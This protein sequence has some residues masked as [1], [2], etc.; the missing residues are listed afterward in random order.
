MKTIKFIGTIA[1]LVLLVL[2]S[3]MTDNTTEAGSAQYAG[4]TVDKETV[5]TLYTVD[6]YETLTLNAPTLIQAPLQKE[7]KYIWE[8][9]GN[10][11]SN[12]ATLNYPCNKYG[13]HTG[14]LTIMNGDNIL[15]RE[16]GVKVRFAYE[17]GVYTLSEYQGKTYFS[18][19]ADRYEGKKVDFDIFR[20]ANGQMPI[21][22]TPAALY[23]QEYNDFGV[24]AK[25]FYIATKNPS[26]MYRL[27]ADTMN[28]TFN[29]SLND[30]TVTSITHAGS[31]KRLTDADVTVCF[32]NA[33]RSLT[34]SQPNFSGSNMLSKV[35]TCSA[36][37]NVE[38]SVGAKGTFPEA[39]V[40]FDKKS[41]S[42]IAGNGYYKKVLF[43]QLKNHDY[44]GTCT[45]GPLTHLNM[46][47]VVKNQDTD[48]Y[49]LFYFY[50]GILRVGKLFQKP[51]TIDNGREIPNTDPTTMAITTLRDKSLLFYSA[52]NRIYAYSLN[53]KG[54]FPAAPI[55]TCPQNGHIVK[56]TLTPDANKL[57]VALN[58]SSG[59]KVGS[60]Y[61]YD[62]T[63]LSITPPLLWKSENSVGRIT[64]L[65][66]RP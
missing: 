57:I 12:D 43:D 39:I 50:P 58:A 41:N 7:V 53:S 29:F 47:S 62:V 52:G 31:P 15:Y 33:I 40:L 54:N 66:Y 5:D 19:I 2:C 55:I 10:V 59:D 24:Q 25:I 63:S 11:I 20:K 44:I 45:A 46:V 13:T 18:Y 37:D 14:R 22:T 34:F 1:C 23:F 16:F 35:D 51:D 9:D 8:I 38:F 4:I 30:Q 6:Q 42:I 49:K 21:G 36:G 61:V 48:T 32:E 64:H 65:V 27:Q 28:V 60:I 26:L 56:M 17:N 3:C